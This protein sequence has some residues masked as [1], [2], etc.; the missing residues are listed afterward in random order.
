MDEPFLLMEIIGIVVAQP[1]SPSLPYK[2]ERLMVIYYR[3]YISLD[4]VC[5][6]VIM[7]AHFRYTGLRI[8]ATFVHRP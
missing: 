2:G 7:L 8:N 3:N 1:I 6:L 4:L 5:W